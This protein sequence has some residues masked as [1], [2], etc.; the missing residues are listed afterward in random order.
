MQWK[1]H[2]ARSSLE[3]DGANPVA[4]DIQLLDRCPGRTSDID[5]ILGVVGRMLGRHRGLPVSPLA[6]RV[7]AERIKE[8]PT[9]SVA[10][11]F[12]PLQLSLP[13]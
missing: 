6:R 10:R 13:Q 4:R 1:Q 3:K 12:V 9:L 7:E 11:S 2:D 8:E 5:S